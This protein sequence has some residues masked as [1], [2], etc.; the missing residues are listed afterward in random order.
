MPSLTGAR[1]YLGHWAETLNFGRKVRDF[2]LFLRADS[3]D[4]VREAFCREEGITYVIRDRSVY[5]DL[6]LPP[7]ERAAGG[8]DPED[9][10]WLL[11]VF[12]QDRVSVYRVREP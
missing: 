3:P 5:D 12:Q 6:Y 2:S 10:P 11:P 9:S 4:A 7:E 8:Y 1:V